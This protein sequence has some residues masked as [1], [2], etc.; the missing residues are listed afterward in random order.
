MTRRA[1]EVAHLASGIDLCYDTFGDRA[2]PA[3]LLVMGLSG[4]LNWWNTELCGLLASAGFFVVRFDNRDVG[5]STILDRA[6]GTRLDVVRAF[7]GLGRTPPYTIS[8][9]ADDALALMSHL[10]VRSAHV[11][12]AS[13]GGMIAQTMA[14]EHQDRIRSLV[15]IMSTTGRRSVGWQ[16]PRLFRNFLGKPPTGRDA[17][18]ARSA[19]VWEQIGSPGYRTPSDEVQARAGETYDRGISASGSLRQ[20]LAVLAQ[21]DR[22][23]KLRELRIPTLVIHGLSDR[24]V[25]VSGGRATAV[26]VPGAELMLV[27]GMGHDLPRALWGEFADGIIRTAARSETTQPR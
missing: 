26:A 21:P 11:A 27:P 12:G 23:L 7:A 25:H 19:V 16:D 6:G 2:D 13:M 5:R 14:V 4:P 1:E 20:T 22:T 3:L 18:I 9:L 17:Y 15:S 10:D 8:D 24:L